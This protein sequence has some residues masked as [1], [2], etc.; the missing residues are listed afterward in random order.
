MDKKRKG[1][2]GFIT[3]EVQSTKAPLL[4]IWLKTTFVQNNMDSKN[5]K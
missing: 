5:P 2:K 3:F 1:K 4:T